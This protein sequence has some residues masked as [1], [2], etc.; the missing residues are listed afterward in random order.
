MSTDFAPK[1]TRTKGGALAP[2]QYIATYTMGSGVSFAN[3]WD[4]NCSLIA[5]EVQG[6]NHLVTFDGT[7]PTSTNGHTL[8]KNQAYH[9]HKDTATAAKFLSLT[10]AGAVM[11][12]QFTVATGATQ[13][14]DT[15]VIKIIPI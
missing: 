3:T 2:A 7:A 8:Y 12:S 4:V 14:P 6:N 10:G 13:L 11:A 5:L 15:S 1:P 9:W